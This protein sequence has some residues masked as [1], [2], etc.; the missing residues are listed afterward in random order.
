MADLLLSIM[1]LAGI[2]LIIG[3]AAMARRGERKRAALMII[4]ALVAFAN[5]AIWVWPA[6]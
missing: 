6:R 1:M 3:A 5:V 4:A 2:A